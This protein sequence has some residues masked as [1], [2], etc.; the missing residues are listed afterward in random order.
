MRPDEYLLIG[1]NKNEATWHLI[2]S[3]PDEFSAFA[4]LGQH[5]NDFDNVIVA[6]LYYK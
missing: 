2:K 5:L 3:F 6:A 1:K 4:A